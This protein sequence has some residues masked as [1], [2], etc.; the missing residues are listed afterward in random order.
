MGSGLSQPDPLSYTDIRSRASVAVAPFD[1]ES[2]CL[3][4][5]SSLPGDPASCSM[6]GSLNLH[7]YR[8]PALLGLRWPLYST[9]FPEEAALEAEAE[10]GSQLSLSRSGLSQRQEGTTA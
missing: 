6:L 3:G 10:L 1:Y 7:L 9:S 2:P 5:L 8:D 4:A